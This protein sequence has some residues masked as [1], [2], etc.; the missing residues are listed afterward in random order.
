M[1]V[2]YMTSSGSVPLSA[3]GCGEDSSFLGV[4]LSDIAALAPRSPSNN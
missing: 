1:A 3:S 2:Q 4:F